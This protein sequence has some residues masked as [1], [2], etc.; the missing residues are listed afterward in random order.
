MKL[1]Y[2]RWVW[3]GRI[4]CWLSVPA[5]VLNFIKP[6][7]WSETDQKLVFIFLLV[8]V[9]FPV[10]LSRICK[11]EFVC[12]KKDEQRIEYKLHKF[13]RSFLG[14]FT[15]SNSEKKKQ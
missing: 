4:I 12:S 14:R 7:W 9:G 11:V 1:K 15:S 10:V 3:Y 13:G 8:F 6:N 5:I 2:S